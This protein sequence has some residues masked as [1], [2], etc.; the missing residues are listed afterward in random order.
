LLE[1]FWETDI[2]GTETLSL[3]RPKDKFALSMAERSIT[4]KIDHYEIVIPWKD[5]VI[6]LSEV[7]KKRLCNLEKR[8]AKSLRMVEEYNS[9][10]L[11]HLEK[12]YIRRVQP[13]SD[14][15]TMKKWSFSS[16]KLRSVLY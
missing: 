15:D 2:S 1:K 5:D 8:L 7:A 11:T 3:L 14:Y 16:Y 6:S 13:S 4:Y 10:I 12:G 9:I